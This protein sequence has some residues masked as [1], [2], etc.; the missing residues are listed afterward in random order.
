LPAIDRN[1]CARPAPNALILRSAGS[2]R[3]RYSAGRQLAGPC[4]TKMSTSEPK[5][6]SPSRAKSKWRDG[7][8]P[9][10]KVVM[11]GPLDFPLFGRVKKK[12]MSKEA[13]IELW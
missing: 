4:N 2:V 1:H 7:E 10:A 3:I 11:T 8:Y 6:V 13:L 12:T 9:R 5:T